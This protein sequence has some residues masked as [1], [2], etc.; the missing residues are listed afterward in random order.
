MFRWGMKT[1]S[2]LVLAALSLQASAAPA[3]TPLRTRAALDAYLAAHAVAATPFAALPPLARRRFIR[4]LSFGGNGLGGFASDD[5]A[6]ELTRDEAERLLAL[7]S[8]QAYVDAIHFRHPDQ[9]PPWR[10][11]KEAGA[12]L[13]AY[14]TLARL[15]D[16][17]AA[18]L[19]GFDERLAPLL[20]D[21]QA[22]RA[23]HD[24]ELLYLGQ[25][26]NRASHL[27][28]STRRS[29]GLERVVAMLQQR[30][31]ARPDDFQHVLDAMLLAR[32]FGEAYHYAAAHP[33][34]AP[35]PTFIDL[36]GPAAD[37]LPSFWEADRSGSLIR[38]RFD[39]AGTQVLVVAGCHFSQD[40]AQDISTDPVLGP[41]FVRHARWLMLPPGDEDPG[42][43]REWN[44]HF[45]GAPAVQIFERRAWGFLPGGWTMPTF[46]ILH[47]GKVV[48][49]VTGWPRSSAS[50]RT[51][52]VAM[53]EKHG[54]LAR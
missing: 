14:D 9:P 3:Q 10:G 42:A 30:H 39:P 49:Q 45:P 32:A 1:F 43:V 26:A 44:Q 24:R 7:F 4:S 51:V 15:L 5:L 2:W 11:E 18:Y 53:L 19:A 20:E 13:E 21:A 16:T 6:L 27:D 38:T 22:L 50:N 48:E 34:L 54:L 41:A 23:L 31:L 40:A 12:V 33:D 29:A 46:L 37:T 35:P 47:D 52:L 28:P 36:L 25:A 8:A 17:P